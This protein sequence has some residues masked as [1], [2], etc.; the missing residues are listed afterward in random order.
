[1]SL[2]QIF[3]Q[4]YKTNTWGVG[5]ITK[6]LSGS[7]SVPE[8]AQPYVDFVGKV[9]QTYRLEKVL[10]VGHGDFEMWRDWQF[11][12][13]DYLGVDVSDEATRIARSKYPNFNFITLDLT[14]TKAIPSADILISK[15]CLQ[16]LPNHAILMLLQKFSSYDFLVICNDILVPFESWLA[17]L[18][19]YGRIRTRIR[20]FL[21]LQSPFF[22]VHR[23]NNVDIEAG[24]FRCLDLKLEPF[25]GSFLGYDLMET[26]DF[27]GPK[28]DG[29]KKRVYFFIKKVTS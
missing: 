29:I 22:L 23:K 19:F 24:D 20:A 16:H 13:I 17:K 1:M 26:F 3:N 11:P 2:G 25:S 18:K 4:I 14:Q 12:G 6:P 5:S 27:D 28:R 10:D 21:S 8:N 15:D 7:G 9:I